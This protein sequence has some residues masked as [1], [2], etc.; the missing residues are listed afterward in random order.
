MGRRL[1]IILLTSAFFI[2]SS[3]Q[4]NAAPDLLYPGHMVRD[5]SWVLS[6]DQE[7]NFF[8]HEENSGDPSNVSA[9]EGMT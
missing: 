4:G 3:L 8:P 1:K 2:L 5:A 9:P 7:G 6:G